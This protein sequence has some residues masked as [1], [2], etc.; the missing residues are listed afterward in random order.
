[1]TYQDI[2]LPI[3]R[4]NRELLLSG[5]GTAAVTHQKDESAVNV[6]T[7]LDIAV[8]EHVSQELALAYPDIGFVGEEHGGDR[9][10]ERFWLMDPIDGT[11]HYIRGLPFSTSM[12]ALIENGQ[13]T[14]SAIYDFVQDD[15][16]WAV[17][18]GG[19]YRNEERLHVSDRSLA[20]SYIGWESHIEHPENMELFMKIRE[21]TILFKAV[22]AGWEYMMVASGKLDARI[23][24]D[25]YGKDYDFAP[26]SLLVSEAGGIVSNIGLDTFDYRNTSFIAANPRMYAELTEG[27]DAIFPKT[28][29]TKNKI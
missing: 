20:E 23:T 12:L 21:K 6:V 29:D 5:W 28:V 14:F 4:Q 11:A 16:Y 3:L 2:V 22:V 19:A 15:M 25:A 26:G 17:R 9:T 18:G 13:V 7:E 10:A 8:E 1:M 27:P 24:F